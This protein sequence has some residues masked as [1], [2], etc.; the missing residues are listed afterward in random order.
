MD[1]SF[2]EVVFAVLVSGELVTGEL[3]HWRVG[4]LASWVTGE[5]GFWRVGSFPSLILD[6][7][8]CT[9]AAYP[10]PAKDIAT[11]DFF[12]CSAFDIS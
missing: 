12:G 10:S 3:G 7:L 5:L 2:V 11:L 4:S 9:I 8:F 6:T 1:P